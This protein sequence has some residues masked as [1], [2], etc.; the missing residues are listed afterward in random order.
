MTDVR[1]LAALMITDMVGYTRM[2]QHDEAR[3]LR[4]LQEHNVLIR[5]SVA[6][7]GGR[8]VKHT[9]DGFLVEFPS[10]L[11]SISCS[12]DIQ[13]LLYDRSKK[14]DDDERFQ[15][16][17]GLHVGDV[18]HRDGDVFGD[19]VNITSRIEPLAMPGG[20]CISQSVQAQVWNKI[21]RPLESLGSRELKNVDLPMEVFR[22]VL[23]WED[24]HKQEAKEQTQGFDR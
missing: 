2:S 21:D 16:R 19:G 10:A 1:K 17:I 13:R 23:P 5:E 20:V 12:I 7:H 15:V 22:V 6:A 9:G 8:E 4:L 18:V 3:A 14:V 24:K 11:Q